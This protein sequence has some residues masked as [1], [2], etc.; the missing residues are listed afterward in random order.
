M[1]WCRRPDLAIVR[2]TFAAVVLAVA[3]PCAADAASRGPKRT[4]VTEVIVHATGGPYCLG[5]KVRY[6]NAGDVGLM[7]RF[8]ERSRVVAIHYIVG[9]DGTVAA[10]VPETEIANHTRDNND[11]SIGIEL[12][13]AGDGI[14]EYPE[15]QVTALARLVA[16]IR[17]RW[18]VPL[19]Q[20]KGHDHVDQSTFSCGG[21][22]VR[23]KQDPGPRFPWQR[24]RDELV[25]A[26]RAVP[27]ATRR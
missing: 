8:F 19:A 25:A 15:A 12:I 21:R 13:N 6:S 4:A 2:S 26:E 27:V 14:D 23:R 5:G 16:D 9:R 11:G 24:L 22:L 18:K 3:L 10:S 1:P 7:K 20:V 17:K